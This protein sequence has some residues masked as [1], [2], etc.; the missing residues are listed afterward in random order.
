MASPQLPPQSQSLHRQ[1]TDSELFA[2]YGWAHGSDA[3]NTAD[4]LG[5]RPQSD[6]TLTTAAVTELVSDTASLSSATTVSSLENGNSMH[7]SRHRRVS[8]AASTAALIEPGMVEAAGAGAAGG[9]FQSSTDA[10]THDIINK[11][12]GN[13]AS[14][15]LARLARWIARSPHPATSTSTS[16]PP[17][18][19]RKVQACRTKLLQCLAVAILSALFIGIIEAA[20][21]YLAPRGRDFS[22]E[23]LAA[24]R[25]ANVPYVAVNGRVMDFASSSSMMEPTST[26]DS[27]AEQIRDAAGTYRGRDMSAMFPAF[28]T[29]LA[30]PVGGG[31]RFADPD[32]ATVVGATAAPAVDA[33]LAMRLAQN[34]GYVVNATTRQLA[35]CPAPSG[36]A[37]GPCFTAAA[38]LLADSAVGY[39][40]HDRATIQQ[41]H[42]DLNSPPALVIIDSMVYD[43]TWYLRLATSWGQSNHTVSDNGSIAAASGSA[44]IPESSTTTWTPNSATAFLPTDMTAALLANLGSTASAALDNQPD[45]AARV[46]VMNK[47]MFAGVLRDALPP[48]AS[49]MNP[50]MLVVGGLIYVLY[51]VKIS[52]TLAQSSSE[53]KNSPSNDVSLDKPAPFNVVLIPVYNESAVTMQKAIESAVNSD[54]AADRKL[55]VVVVDGLAVQPGESHRDAA[56]AVRGI[57]GYAGK[58]PAQVEYESVGTG[59]RRLNVAQVYAGR[60][61]NGNAATA[62]VPYV[63]IVKSGARG[64]TR[65]PG[66]RGKRDSM[67]ILMQYLSAIV[68]AGGED[69]LAG[70]NNYYYLSPLERALHTALTDDLA[71]DPHEF[72]Y[73]T[74][75]D[76]DT[77]MSRDAMTALAGV[78][79]REHATLAVHGCMYPASIKMTFWSLLQAYPW[80]HTHHLAPA[81]DSA[82]GAVGRAWSG[83]FATYRIVFPTTKATMKIAGEQKTPC[84]VARG[85]LDAFTERP[86]T[87]HERN[88]LWLGEDRSL[89]ALLLAHHD[90]ITGNASQLAYCPTAIA[91][92]RLPTTFCGVINVHTRT[93]T[94]RLHTLAH[95]T[96]T[97]RSLSRPW[98]RIL[99]RVA[100]VCD[101]IA[102]LLAPA[103]TTFLYFMI[104]RT[105]FY[106]AVKKCPSMTLV[107][108]DVLINLAFAALAVLQCVLLLLA[109]AATSRRALLRMVLPVLVYQIA[110]MLFWQLVVP[111]VALWRADWGDMWCDSVPVDGRCAVRPHGADGDE[112]D[113]EIAARA[114]GR[115]K[116]KYSNGPAMVAVPFSVAARRSTVAPL[117]AA[118]MQPHVVSEFASLFDAAAATLNRPLATTST[119]A[120][121]V[122]TPAATTRPTS[123]NSLLSLTSTIVPGGSRDG[124]AQRSDTL[125]SAVTIAMPFSPSTASVMSTAAFPP[126]LTRPP[127]DTL[128]P[129]RNN[130]HRYHSPPPAPHAAF[131]LRNSLASNPPPPPPSSSSAFSSLPRIVS[132]TTALSSRYHS[133]TNSTRTSLA[134]SGRPGSVDSTTTATTE[135]TTTTRTTSSSSLSLPPPRGT[136]RARSALRH[137]VRE[138]VREIISTLVRQQQEQEQ[139]QQQRETPGAPDTHRLQRELAMRFGDALVN[140]FGE[141]IEECVEEVLLERM[142]LV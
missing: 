89:P 14:L 126:T 72:E 76:G 56:T 85:L 30:Q 62:A 103:A 129:R 44:V 8:S 91:T 69:T 31:A 99:L 54:Y 139:Q 66:T 96:K 111:V 19:R 49:R 58:V 68:G 132:G 82:I 64:E 40:V 61:N 98:R 33:W 10:K 75:M 26:A 95:L 79:R 113:D 63:V 140:D 25:D 119:S 100:A 16:S 130:Y 120:A 36:A 3:F 128:T 9:T 127:S 116:R 50:V 117:P 17:R 134:T 107:H 4:T 138:Q 114:A 78:L 23:E 21:S 136:D 123:Q 84:L 86:Q 6:D 74:V 7:R 87:M 125:N 20:G 5:R 142:A 73:L 94:A 28:A 115:D 38:G 135:T 43:V 13:A 104:A 15:H 59:A 42:G 101:A 92:T 53:A 83:G 137:A 41:S 34:D 22:L 141:F 77:T 105:I 67:L 37:A 108:S 12:N 80:F 71:L 39:V 97:T 55:V 109:A 110:G 65:L 60:F 1:P 52:M 29:L 11:I 133:G 45:R 46:R 24:M 122:A 18:Q 70:T 90:K 102:M 48:R 81:L 93:Y 118:E 2:E 121:T 35:T 57:L 124:F 88:R 106:T 32:M 27:M 47:L 51:I 112:D 131:L